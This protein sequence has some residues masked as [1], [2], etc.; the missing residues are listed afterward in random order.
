MPAAPSRAPSLAQPPDLA[1]L[2]SKVCS[3]PCARSGSRPMADAG[4][5][6]YKI[7]TPEMVKA[8]AAATARGK[9]SAVIILTPQAVEALVAGR[10]YMLA[11]ETGEVVVLASDA[12]VFAAYAPQAPGGGG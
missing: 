5:P 1:P 2:A 4:N 11:M 12:A 10:P 3:R 9:L 7:L 8:V 6:I